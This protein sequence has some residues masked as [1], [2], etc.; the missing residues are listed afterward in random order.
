MGYRALTTL[1]LVTHFAYLAYVVLGGFLAWRWPRAI[2]PHLAASA[3]GLVAISRPTICPLT[4]A[5]DWSRQ[6]AGEA[7]LTQG[8]V[9]R[10][11]EGVLYPARYTAVLQ[12]LAAI[13]VVVSW[14]GFLLRRRARRRAG[15][16]ERK[17][18]GSSEGA[19]TV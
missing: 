7:A 8:F 19:A 11:I 5:E 4:W 14:A 9:D 15:T 13:A 1:V 6:R 3:W 18:A 12:A 10:Y 2:W 16:P 17:S